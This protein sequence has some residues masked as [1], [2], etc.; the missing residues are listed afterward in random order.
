MKGTGKGW[1]TAEYS[2]LP[3]STLTRTAAKPAADARVDAPMNSTADWTRHARR[4]RSEAAGRAH[5]LRWIAT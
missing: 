3:R 4:C 1:I 5:H 2:M